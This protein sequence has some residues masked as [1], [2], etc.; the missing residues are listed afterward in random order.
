[1]FTPHN[2]QHAS[3]GTP[4]TPFHTTYYYPESLPQPP[5]VHANT[6]PEFTTSSTRPFQ[7]ADMLIRGQKRKQ[8]TN[9]NQD[10]RRKFT[11]TPIRPLKGREL[12]ARIQFLDDEIARLKKDISGLARERTLLAGAAPESR[13]YTGRTSENEKLQAVFSAISGI[14]KWNLPEFLYGQLEG[15]DSSTTKARRT[16]D[17][18]GL[19]LQGDR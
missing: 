12:R 7:H 11:D 19:K 5:S 4:T 13:A 10:P 15:V 16:V 2:D 8:P 9:V 14:A 18:T 6:L 3:Y 17:T 1:M